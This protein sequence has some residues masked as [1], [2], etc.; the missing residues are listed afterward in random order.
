MRTKCREVKKRRREE[1]KKRKAKGKPV[2]RTAFSSTCTT[3]H[4]ADVS[5]TG[6]TTN[7]YQPTV[8]TTNCYHNQLLSINTTHNLLFTTMYS[9]LLLP[10]ITEWLLLALPK[11]RTSHPAATRG[12]ACLSSCWL[13]LSSDSFWPSHSFSHS[14][15]F[16]GYDYD[17]RA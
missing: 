10:T 1:E 13:H 14:C 9:H 2:V 8:T 11:C 4:S 17:V 16:E 7:C 3:N 5:R 6:T 15:R 12:A